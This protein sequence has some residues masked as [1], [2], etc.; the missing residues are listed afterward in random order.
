MIE[1][2]FTEVLK[3]AA[4]KMVARQVR[5]ILNSRNLLAHQENSASI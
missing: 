3:T 4:I 2:H 1:S 5:P